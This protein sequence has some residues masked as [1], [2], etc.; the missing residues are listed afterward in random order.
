MG[1]SAP[2]KIWLVVCAVAIAIHLGGPPLLD[3]DEGRNAEV[4]R[5][6]AATNDY[7]VPRLNALPYLDKPIVY[8]A[9]AAA[10]MEILGPTELAARLPAYLFTLATAALLL[11]WTRRRIGADEAVVTA[12][13]FLAMPLTVAFARIVIFDSTLTFFIV[14]AIVAFH[15]AIE[16]TD[17][18][19][20]W[21]AWT[22]IALGV[23]T[24]GPV[25]IA[26]PLLVAI[27]YA[28]WR[29]AF[30]A[31][32][33]SGG[34]IAFGAIVTPWV[35]AISLQ[36]PDF[37]RYVLVTETATRMTTEDLDRAGPPW[38]FLPYLLGGAMPWTV[39]AVS[40]W[41]EWMRREPRIVF[42]LL[43]IVV[44]LV[45]FSLS[46]SKRGQ[47]IL[48]L[49]PPIAVLIGCSW[50]GLRVRGAAI[51]VALFGALLLVAASIPRLTA[52]MAPELIG[53]TR[54]TALALGAV[55]L[56]GGLVAIVTKRR[57][58]AVIGLSFPVVAMPLLINPLLDA[59]GQRRSSERLAGRISSTFGP[60]ATVIGIEAFTGSL[61]FYLRRPV[62]V[63]TPDGSELTSNYILEQYERFS[64][65]PASTIKTP[66]WLDQN[67]REC[68]E[69]RVYVV[70]RKDV[71]HQRRLEALGARRFATEPHYLAYAWSG[72]QGP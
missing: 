55:L 38:Y 60:R 10:L 61:A 17:R 18:R 44:P 26:L 28:V 53:S 19:W 40:S 42:L 14:V 22:A 43:W 49:L 4:A 69:P 24:K 46:Q 33:S 2:L 25:A 36:Q 23:L 64:A 68:C 72:R 62:I 47:Y 41:R 65:D 27:P 9:A 67:L 39:V 45:F 7:V 48:P 29:K 35:W 57:A 70:L 12:I 34:L 11:W 1:T 8:F 54:R 59:L 21:L 52:E 13:A 5:E 71:H 32:W 30:R 56:A 6:M 31:L 15:E 3:P 58:I 63:A 20:T 37:L 16:T 66:S 51:I 50:R